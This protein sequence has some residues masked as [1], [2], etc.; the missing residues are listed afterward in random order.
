VTLRERGSSTEVQFELEFA[1]AA[2]RDQVINEFGAAQGQEDTLTRL[3]GALA[4]MK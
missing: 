2:L 3:G 1:T 4:K